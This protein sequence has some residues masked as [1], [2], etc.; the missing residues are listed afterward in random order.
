M[1]KSHHNE[2]LKSTR[3]EVNSLKK[4]APATDIEVQQQENMHQEA[5]KV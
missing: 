2:T 3:K 4:D 5:T 1:M